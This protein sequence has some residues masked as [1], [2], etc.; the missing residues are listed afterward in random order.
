MMVEMILAGLAQAATLSPAER[1]AAYR[2]AG[3]ALQDGAWRGC[4]GMSEV[5]TDDSWMEGETQPDL[6]GDGKNELLLGDQGIGCYG[7]TGQGYVV[8]TRGPQGWK[9]IDRGPGIPRFLDTRGKDGWRDIE[10]GGPGFCFPV[11][12]WNGNA[13]QL[14]RHQYDDK[15][16]KPEG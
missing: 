7:N 1:E 13:Y 3:F 6:N 12:R 10:V 5:F 4:E 9:V 2:A 11:L 15:A 16:C 14:N 8:L